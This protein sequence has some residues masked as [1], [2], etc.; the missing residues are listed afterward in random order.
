MKSALSE[1]LR[2]DAELRKFNDSEMQHSRKV[3]STFRN[4]HDLDSYFAIELASDWADRNK[5]SKTK[6]V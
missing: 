3:C 6:R 2:P 1:Q 5:Y 4:F